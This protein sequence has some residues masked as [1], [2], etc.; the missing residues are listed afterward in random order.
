MSSNQTLAFTFV[1]VLLYGVHVLLLLYGVEYAKVQFLHIH[2][3]LHQVELVNVL[4]VI[5]VIRQ[6]KLIAVAYS[7]LTY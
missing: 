3:L 4:P 6:E 5:K 2:I 1:H 7:L